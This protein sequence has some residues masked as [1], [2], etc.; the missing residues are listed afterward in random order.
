MASKFV[1]RDVIINK[2]DAMTNGNIAII[3]CWDHKVNKYEVDFNNG[4]VGWYKRS[5][6]KIL[7][8]GEKH[9]V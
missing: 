6:L 4:F 9:G 5:E 1:G 7:D 3:K 2:H 8:E